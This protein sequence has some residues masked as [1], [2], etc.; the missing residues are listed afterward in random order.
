[1][2]GFQDPETYRS[3]LESLQTGISVVDLEKKIVLWSDGAERITGFLRHEVVGRS[4]LANI[5]PHCNGNSCESCQERC[6]IESAIRNARPAEAAGYLHHKAGQLVAVHLWTS[7]VRDP[8]GSIVGA[9]KN[10]AEKHEVTSSDHRQGDL[11][12]SGC[13]DDVTGISNHAIM[14]SHLRET[15]GTFSELQVPFGIVL[16]RLEE[17]NNFRANF[18]PEAGA[19]LLRMAAQTIEGALW[20]TDIAG[21]WGDDQFLM[22]LNGCGDDALLAVR[23][24]IRRMLTYDAI[25]WWGEK[26]SLPISLGHAAARAG[27]TAELL[28]E[29]A[30][31]ALNGDATQQ[32]RPATKSHVAGGS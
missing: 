6:P 24:R 18:T 22:I 14:Q 9:T 2:P 31:Q 16:V 21:R 20:K 23:E 32:I 13:V 17:L 3:I 12:A 25:D 27:D 19:A 30:Q 7:P 5:L 29:R 10:F 1:M 28:L 8:R 26:L 4:F 11:T 15:L